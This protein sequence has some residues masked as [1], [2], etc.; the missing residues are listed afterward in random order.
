MEQDWDKE[1]YYENPKIIHAKN[2]KTKLS[3]KCWKGKKQNKI[4]KI[5]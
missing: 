1:L 3:E 2:S 4:K 5:V